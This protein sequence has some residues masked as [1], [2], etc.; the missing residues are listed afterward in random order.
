MR[1]AF[2]L[3]LAAATA[4]APAAALSQTTTR[5]ETRPFYGATVTLEEGVRVFRPLPPQDRVIINPNGATPLSLGFEEKR[6]V[7]HNYYYGGGSGAVEPVHVG[8]VGPGWVGSHHGGK[9]SHGHHG[10]TGT[11]SPGGHR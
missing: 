9:G 5:I 6:A 8:G 2:A 4:L 10:R 7:S 11:F 3:V 1:N